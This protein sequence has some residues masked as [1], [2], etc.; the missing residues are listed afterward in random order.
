MAPA[1]VPGV[2][3]CK[4]ESILPFPTDH[5]PS[6]L[7]PILRNYTL[8]DVGELRLNQGVPR[9][10]ARAMETYQPIPGLL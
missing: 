7:G 9:D 5:L 8:F 2:P 1:S 3:F 6:G 4:I 10:I